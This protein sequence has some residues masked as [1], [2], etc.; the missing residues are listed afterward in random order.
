MQ[1]SHSGDENEEYDFDATSE[2]DEDI[3]LEG[4]EE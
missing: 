1:Q 2:D 4:D 3:P